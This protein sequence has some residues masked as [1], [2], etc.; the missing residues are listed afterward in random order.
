MENSH[1]T[2]I[3]YHMCVLQGFNSS[4]NIELNK[5]ES[6]EEFLWNIIHFNAPSLDLTCDQR[7][8]YI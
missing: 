4:F 6:K 7:Y 5:F 8:V 1:G 2:G 3:I